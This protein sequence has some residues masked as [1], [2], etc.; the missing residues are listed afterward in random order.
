MFVIAGSMMRTATSPRA[1]PASTDAMSLN[2]ATVLVWL[3]GTAGTATWLYR[4]VTLQQP[5]ALPDG[6]KVGV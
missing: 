6:E 1:S 3:T 2:S 4:G 5:R